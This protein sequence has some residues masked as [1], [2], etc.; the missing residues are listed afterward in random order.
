MTEIIKP[1]LA[2]TGI[3]AATIVL[4]IAMIAVS[5]MA[6][7][8]QGTCASNSGGQC[9]SNNNGNPSQSATPE[10]PAGANPQPNPQ[11]AN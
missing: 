4:G 3:L 5:P 2:L 8:D 9:A 11:R 7:A 1:R 6:F 10:V